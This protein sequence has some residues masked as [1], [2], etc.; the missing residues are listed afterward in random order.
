MIYWATQTISTSVLPYHDIMNAGAMT[1]IGEKIKEW[2]GSA[3]VPAGFCF[4]SHDHN[5]RFF[6][7]NNSHAPREWAERFFNVQHWVHQPRGGHFGAMEEPELLAEDIR[8]FFRP[9]RELKQ[10]SI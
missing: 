4:F 10:E 8:T 7:E 9:L 3:K 2:T 1:W 5:H 6:A